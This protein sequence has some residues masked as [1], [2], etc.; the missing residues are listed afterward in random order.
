VEAINAVRDQLGSVLALFDVA[1][2]EVRDPVAENLA[3]LGAADQDRGARQAVADQLF[4]QLRL[5]PSEGARA[6]PGVGLADPVDDVG[7]VLADTQ[8]AAV[9]RQP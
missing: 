3:R 5:V 4:A 2:G 7:H 1:P 9:A 6:S 8:L